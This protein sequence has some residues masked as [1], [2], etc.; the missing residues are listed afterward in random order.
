MVTQ[1]RPKRLATGKFQPKSRR[2]CRQPQARKTAHFNCLCY[3]GRISYASYHVGGLLHHNVPIAPAS[4]LDGPWCWGLS[5][6][7]AIK[8][9]PRFHLLC[10]IF[11]QLPQLYQ[12]NLGQMTAWQHARQLN[13]TC[14][15]SLS[16][17]ANALPVLYLHRLQRA[18]YYAELGNLKTWRRFIM[19]GLATQTVELVNQ[20][21][22]N[23]AGDGNHF[24]T[25]C[26]C[27]PGALRWLPLAQSSDHNSK[28][29]PPHVFWR[30]A[31]RSDVA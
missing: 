13:P 21:G 1:P 20:L 6:C 3:L 27:N 31:S 7:I 11:T 25:V 28:I 14:Q 17:N 15:Y 18:H 9:N 16:R 30:R 22:I 10:C 5:R 29:F 2:F 24:G 19:L 8:I 26:F 12:A 23:A 4:R